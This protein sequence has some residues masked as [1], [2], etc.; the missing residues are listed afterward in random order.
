MSRD[1]DNKPYGADVTAEDAG[2]GA[3][4]TSKVEGANL[5]APDNARLL[6]LIS[7]LETR[8][9]QLTRR[10]GAPVGTPLT[11]VQSIPQAHMTKSA[12]TGADYPP[13]NLAVVANGNGVALAADG[14][15]LNEV[16]IMPTAALPSASEEPGK[17]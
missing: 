7:A 13:S 10:V 14:T 9:N 16:A 5:D 8:L 2:E 4:E 3:E 17:Q 1:A 12:V 11:G 6:T 15:P